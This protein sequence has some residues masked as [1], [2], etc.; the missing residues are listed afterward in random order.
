M[1]P[2]DFTPPQRPGNA[3]VP[4][5]FDASMQHDP[6]QPAPGSD[7]GKRTK[8]LVIIG[9]L[10]LVLALALTLGSVVTYR[11]FTACLNPDD[12]RTLTGQAVQD[13]ASFSPRDAF[14]IATIRYDNRSANPTSGQ[15]DTPESVADKLASFYADKS[16][17]H[18]MTITLSGGYTTNDDEASAQKRL[19]TLKSAL[20]KRGVEPAAIISEEPYAIESGSELSADSDELKSAKAY[21]SL[22]SAP[23]CSE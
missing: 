11:A 7:N 6:I 19:D 23:T 8:K 22:T 2:N 17:T 18:P 5:W 13:E 14:Y 16:A 3:P 20:E 4:E 1:N 10:S 9:A 12:Y 21:V 15:A